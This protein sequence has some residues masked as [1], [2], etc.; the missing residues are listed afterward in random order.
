MPK[1]DRDESRINK[2]ECRSQLG[3][4]FIIALS[5]AINLGHSQ[6]AKHNYSAR[7]MWCPPTSSSNRP[8]L[9]KTGLWPANSHLDRVCGVALTQAPLQSYP[10]LTSD[11][12]IPSAMLSC[13]QEVVEIPGGVLK[14]TGSILQGDLLVPLMYNEGK[15]NFKYTA[16]FFPKV[17]PC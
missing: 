8:F 13:Y 9:G 4:P 16:L 2:E 12:A 3:Q 11:G 7:H 10:T 1:G 15:Y 17:F 6:S 5:R 14:A